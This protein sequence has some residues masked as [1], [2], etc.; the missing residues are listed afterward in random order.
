M[1]KLGIESGSS[2]TNGRT[3]NYIFI[4]DFEIN[5]NSYSSTVQH[6]NNTRYE[7]I[8]ENDDI[9]MQFKR[10]QADYMDKYTP[11]L[12]K[13]LLETSFDTGYRSQAELFFEELYD[14]LG[15]IADSIL[16]NIYLQHMYDDKYIIKHL[17][18]IVMNLPPERRS[19]IQI[20][21]VAGLSNP[22]IEIQDLSVRCFE[23]W[24]DNRHLP[25]LKELLARTNT[26][27]FKEYLS[28]VINELEVE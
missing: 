24:K 27:W 26:K 13:L 11:Q 5:N 18:F 21:P 19:I 3:V 4:D 12:T 17:L 9:V 10:M 25:A 20:I 14:K 22:D 1:G 23:S 16:Q 8:I 2:N 15:T 7:S 28:E 6:N